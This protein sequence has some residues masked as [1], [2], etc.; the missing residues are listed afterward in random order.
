MLPKGHHG[1]C[2]KVLNNECLTWLLIASTL[3]GQHP[4][5]VP[6]FGHPVLSSSKCHLYAIE[7]A[8]VAI[9]DCSVQ[10][11]DT[12]SQTGALVASSCTMTSEASSPSY[13]LMSISHVMWMA[14]PQT[15]K[16]MMIHKSIMS[17]SNRGAAD[18]SSGTCSHSVAFNLTFAVVIPRLCGIGTIQCLQL[19]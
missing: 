4:C 8:C 2:S 10:S 11:S 6:H 9:I 18:G 17:I 19:F 14:N 5:G 15:N 12:K 16:V 13:L 3:P 1:K 7:S